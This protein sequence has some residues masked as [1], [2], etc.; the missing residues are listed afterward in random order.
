MTPTN[1]NSLHVIAAETPK[2]LGTGSGLRLSR[3][4]GFWVVAA[5]MTAL[6][7]FATA[8]SSLYGLYKRQD[9]LSSLTI[10]LVYAVFAA[11]IVISLLLVGHVSDWYGRRTVLIPAML[12]GLAAAVVFASSMSLPAL[13]LGRV[14]TGL[15]VGSAVATA[16]AYLAD[17]DSGPLAPATRRAQIVATVANVGGLAL[18][19]VIAGLLAANVTTDPRKIFV[20]FAAL[21]ALAVVGT[22]I[23]PETRPVP[24]P[25]PR[26]RPQRIAVP[27]AARRQFGAALAG[28]FLVF[29]V[30]GVYA[31]LSTTFLAVT[32][33][34]NSP[35][36]AGLA[37]FVSFSSGLLAQ[38]LTI[39]WPLRRLLSLGVPVLV[40]GLGVLVSAAWVN[41]PSLLLFF[42]GA[43]LS[44]AGSGAI[45]RSTLTV[46]LTTAPAADRGGA[47]A[48]FFV[49]GYVG[50]SLP[51]VGAGIAL[52]S[53]GLKTILLIFGGTVAAGILV[54]SPVLL[55]LSTDD[56]A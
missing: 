6:T 33:Q 34:Q 1:P 45:Y 14:L 49:V 37:V 5:C 50:L 53:I 24:I 2:Q 13:Y 52:V 38:V 17:L 54:A 27:G 15:A 44:G 20:P 48:L 25:R 19:P 7:A 9:H 46:V 31:G 55:R 26:Y 29:A 35:I 23:A 47:L 3:A 21:L 28:D 16:T 12:T 36:L 10:T 51:V 30:Y 8:P 18:G 22:V 56:E 11:G 4:T 41:P 32:L 42:A 39:R 40:V 43:F